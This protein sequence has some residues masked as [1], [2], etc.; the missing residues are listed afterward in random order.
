MIIPTRLGQGN[1][2]MVQSGLTGEE[3]DWFSSQ[4]WELNQPSIVRILSRQANRMERPPLSG[5]GEGVRRS[6]RLHD[7][8]A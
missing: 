7:P 6:I 4:F 8:E 1:G 3:N 5:E 2:R